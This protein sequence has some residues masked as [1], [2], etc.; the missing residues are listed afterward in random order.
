MLPILSL[1][2]Q[3][4]RLFRPLAFTWIFTIY[5]DRAFDEW[6]V[7]VLGFV[8]LPWT[9]LVYALAYD[10]RE[11]SGIGWLFVALALLALAPLA[12][13]LLLATLVPT[14]NEGVV[15]TWQWE[16]LPSLGL[17]IGFYVD[18]LALF[19]GLLVTFIG[20]LV[21]VY[22]GYYYKGDQSAWRFLT[23]MLLFMTSMLGLVLAGDVLTLFLFWEGTSILS[24]LL[25]AYKGGDKLYIPS[26]QIDTLRQYV[27]GDGQDVWPWT[28]PDKPDRFDCSK[29]DQWEIVFEHGDK[30]GMYLHFKTSE[31]ENELLLDHGNTDVQRKLYYRELIARFGHHNAIVWMLGE[32]N[33][34]TTAQIKDFS[35]YIKFVDPYD[36]PITIHRNDSFVSKPM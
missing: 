30:L 13:F 22:T 36:H 7:P 26:D 12:A 18:T 5:V 6:W 2:A 29:L 1:Q 27:G 16:W 32:E 11:V 15:H 3:E 19:F 28:A 23:Y 21:I 34:N 10:G 20:I 31:T 25:V 24:Y 9:T 8:F 35:R 14:A 17:S 33:T 4:G